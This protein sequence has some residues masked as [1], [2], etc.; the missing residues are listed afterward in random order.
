MNTIEDL[1]LFNGVTFL[2]LLFRL[3]LL[4][5]LVALILFIV[6]FIWLRFYKHDKESSFVLFADKAFLYSISV[7][8]FLIS[9]EWYYLINVNGT[10]WFKW[11]EFPLDLLNIY[12][13]L[14]PEI[15]ILF[16]LFV[17]FFMSKNKIKKNL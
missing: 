16:L 4:A 12:L 9:F 17:I 10:H 1:F 8:V 14:L 7:V 2:K 3:A 11:N 13:L 15:A 6:Y 5:F